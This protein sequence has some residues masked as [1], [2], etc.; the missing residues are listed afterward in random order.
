MKKILFDMD[1]TITP[2]QEVPIERLTSRGYFI[3]LPPVENVIKAIYY[4]NESGFEVG[5]LSSVFT[6][7]HSEEEKNLW[8]D[9]ELGSLIKPE[10]RFF[11]PY[12]TK[13][14]D[15]IK[16]NA[17]EWAG[18]MLIDDYTM[19][20]WDWRCAGGIACKIYNGVNGK[21]GSWDGFS[22]HANMSPKDMAIQIAGILNGCK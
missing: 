19:N 6:D 10:N 14:S 3:S 9:K 13:K 20:L 4:L 15:Y 2:W 12:G 21:N 5:I 7:D 16:E 8:L 11:A 18:A 1:G 22:I 17:P